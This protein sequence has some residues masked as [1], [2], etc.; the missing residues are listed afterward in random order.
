MALATV[1][2]V[3]EQW[4]WCAGQGSKPVIICLDSSLIMQPALGFARHIKGTLVATVP[5]CDPVGRRTYKYTVQYESTD[6][7]N[8][9]TPLAC[10]DIKGILCKGCLTDFIEDLVSQMA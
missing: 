6:L 10:P 9:A 5:F 3:T 1:D 2:Y 8:P 4:L 7:K